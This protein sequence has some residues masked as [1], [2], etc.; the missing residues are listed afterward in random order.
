MAAFLIGA[1]PDIRARPAWEYGVYIE[2]PDQYEWQD[3]S[4]QVL[5][6]NTGSFLH[7]MG[8]PADVQVDA[9]TGRVQTVLLNHLGRQGWEL[10]NVVVAAE[11]NIYWL[12]R[13]R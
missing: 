5:G 12:K 9:R 10:V 7:R 11:R 4:Q 2:S 6:T 1:D 3:A 13:P 8:L